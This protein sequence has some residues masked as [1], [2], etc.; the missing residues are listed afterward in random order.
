MYYNTMVSVQMTWVTI[1]FLITIL[2]L[3]LSM[4]YSTWVTGISPMPSGRKSRAIM[5]DLIPIEP[6]YCVDMGS[7]WGGLLIMLSK[8]FPDATI[9]GFESSWVPYLWSKLICRRPNICIIRKDFLTVSYPQDAVF[10]CY[11]CPEGMKRIAKHRFEK[12]SWLISHTFALPDRVPALEY[13]LSDR[14]RT[15][16]Y[17]YENRS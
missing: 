10:L 3:P 1:F 12:S 6:T 14:Y 2:F 8:R 13:R 4:V 7:G 17:V 5:L 11:L 9:V 15:P 16:I